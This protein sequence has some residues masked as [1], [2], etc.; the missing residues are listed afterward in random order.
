MTEAKAQNRKLT[1]MIEPFQ[2]R[3]FPIS[4]RLLSSADTFT[5]PDPT[6]S[7]SNNKIGCADQVVKQEDESN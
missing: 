3:Q 2:A 1:L 5:K 6:N 4:S 7:F